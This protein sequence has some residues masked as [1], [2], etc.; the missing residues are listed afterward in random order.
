MKTNRH[1]YGELLLILTVYTLCAWLMPKVTPFAVAV[2]VT[3][4]IRLH[5][6]YSVMRVCDIV[7]F[8]LNVGFLYT[9]FFVA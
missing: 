4:I 2:G 8:F 1:T 9:I 6:G 5:V 3:A 7:L